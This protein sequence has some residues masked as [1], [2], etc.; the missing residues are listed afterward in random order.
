L[1]GAM[2][3]G[4]VVATHILTFFVAAPEGH[5]RAEVLHRTGHFS[6]TLLA[7]ALLGFVVAGVVRFLP[8]RRPV[9]QLLAV[10]SAGWLL[11]EATERLSHHGADWELGIIG[12]GLVVQALVAVAGGLLLRAVRV[13]LGLVAKRRRPLFDQATAAFRPVAVRTFT[14]PA[15]LAGAAGL[16]GPP[17]RS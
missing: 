13:V 17:Y 5:H 4:G 16:R 8:L 6:F 9:A 15:V 3:A 11:L 12:L 7:A 2:A 10:Q 1:I 14:R